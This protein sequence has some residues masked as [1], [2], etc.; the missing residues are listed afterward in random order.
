MKCSKCGCEVNATPYCPN[1]GNPITIPAYQNYNFTPNA[2]TTPTAPTVTQANDGKQKTIRIAVISAAA[3]LLAI[4]IAVTSVIIHNSNITAIAADSVIYNDSQEDYCVVIKNSKNEIVSRETI[5][6]NNKY[7]FKNLEDGIYFVNMKSLNGK[8]DTIYLKKIRIVQD[9]EGEAVSLEITKDF[10]PTDDYEDEDFEDIEI[11]E[12]A[13]ELDIHSETVEKLVDKIEYAGYIYP[14]IFNYGSFKADELSNEMIL[15]IAF[16]HLDYSSHKNENLFVENYDSVTEGKGYSACTDSKNEEEM[17]KYIFGDD[18]EY[19]LTDFD[20]YSEN[21]E[22]AAFLGYD[23]LT[24]HTIYFKDGKFTK[25]NSEGG[26]GDVPY[27]YLCLSS[28]QQNGDDISIYVD[29]AFVDVEYPNDEANADITHH[30]YKEY[31]NGSY[32]SKIV[33]LDADDTYDFVGDYGS[34]DEGGWY[35]GIFKYP[36]TKMEKYSDQMDCCCFTF[37]KDDDGEY[38]LTAFEK[39]A[40]KPKTEVQSTQASVD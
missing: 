18:I 24:Y 30:F 26:G 12:E 38:Y 22:Y 25:Y 9:Y 6:P 19:Q 32:K 1:C 33:S 10:E 28:A 4:V 29:K 14:T 3:V 11:G 37:S 2:P 27:M 36:F 39:D 5:K 40:Q 13:K 17:I 15:A 34:D 21:S 7:Q 35:D 8:G 23:T 31:E 20:I 16:G